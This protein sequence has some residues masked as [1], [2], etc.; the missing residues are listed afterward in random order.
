MLRR[1]SRGIRARSDAAKTSGDGARNGRVLVGVRRYRAD[2]ARGQPVQV[3]DAPERAWYASTADD[4]GK[5]L[6]A[7]VFTKNGAA[8][9]WADWPAARAEDYWFRRRLREDGASIFRRSRN[10]PERRPSR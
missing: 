10:Q 9:R 7:K 2:G 6:L 4:A 5:R 3:D 8:R 1:T